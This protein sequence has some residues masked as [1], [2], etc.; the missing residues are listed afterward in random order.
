MADVIAT[1][2]QIVTT[3]SKEAVNALNE[4]SQAARNTRRGPTDLAE[5]FDSSA[6]RASMQASRLSEALVKAGINV[7]PLGNVLF[8]IDNVLQRAGRNMEA[9]KKAIPEQALT[10]GFVAGIGAVAV[11]AKSLSEEIDKLNEGLGKTKAGFAGNWW[12]GIKEIASGRVTDYGIVNYTPAGMAARAVLGRGDKGEEGSA[13][14]IN[15]ATIAKQRRDAAEGVV[16][17]LRKEETAT[18][19]LVKWILEQTTV[20]KVSV[21][22]IS[23]DEIRQQQDAI[24]ARRTREKEE[25]SVWKQ[26]KE[27]REMASLTGK[28]D[29]EANAMYAALLAGQSPVEV[30]SAGLIARESAEESKR[31]NDAR[32]RLAE[33]IVRDEDQL[34]KR[35]RD[36]WTQDLKSGPKFAG[37][38]EV[39]SAE[40][41]KLQQQLRFEMENPNF[42]DQARQEEK[43]IL[44]QQLEYQKRVDEKLGELVSKGIV[45]PFSMS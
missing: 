11:H 34:D 28:T 38:M 16:K 37:A 36:A 43:D 41:Y 40:A 10:A 26:V 23:K 14:E 4:V 42:G 2:L 29:V 35:N 7:G 45:V 30:R 9:F 3:G 27:K 5:R 12:Q 31:E 19:E 6:F 13:L 21:D 25:E 22:K 18:E 17:G 44:K 33:K 32:R 39:G 15:E 24:E 20:R 1:E 8:S